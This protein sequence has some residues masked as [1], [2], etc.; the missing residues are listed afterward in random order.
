M[1]VMVGVRMPCRSASYVWETNPKKVQVFSVVT[2]VDDVCAQRH[3]T[4]DVKRIYTALEQQGV[5]IRKHGR[6][7]NASV[8]KSVREEH[9]TTM[10]QL[11]NLA[12]SKTTR[13]DP[14]T[15]IRWTE[16]KLG[17]YMA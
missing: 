2:A 1:R 10:N 15:T 4:V 5:R 3:E 17:H 9:P 12:C 6:D 11:H 14:K 7:N 16:G 8:A 13:E